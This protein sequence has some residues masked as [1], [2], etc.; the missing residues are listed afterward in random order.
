MT[1]TIARDHFYFGGAVR[2]PGDEVDVP[3]QA[4]LVSL[5]E[6]G[7]VGDAPAEPKQAE[8]PDNKM[9]PAPLNK[10]EASANR[11]RKG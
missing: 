4:D 2:H 10:A 5:E 3:V 6:R 9:N 7:L 8:L 1:K 11:R